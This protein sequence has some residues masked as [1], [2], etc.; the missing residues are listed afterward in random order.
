MCGFLAAVVRITLRQLQTMLSGLLWRRSFIRMTLLVWHLSAVTL[1]AYL[2]MMWC[3]AVCLMESMAC[4]VVTRF[5]RYWYVYLVIDPGL[6]FESCN[7]II[8]DANKATWYTSKAKHD[9]A[10]ALCGNGLGL[11]DDDDIHSIKVIE[12][13]SIMTFILRSEIVHCVITMSI[14][15]KISDSLDY[16]GTSTCDANLFFLFAISLITLS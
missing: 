6:W 3:L 16:F 11:Q 9:Q 12:K 5:S 8:S 14:Y 2:Y 4:I 10:K 1:S 7:V 15:L 13:F